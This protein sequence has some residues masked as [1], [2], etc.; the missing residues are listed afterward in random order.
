VTRE[1][2]EK[3]NKSANNWSSTDI[4]ERYDRFGRILYIPSSSSFK[5][6]RPAFHIA[7]ILRLLGSRVVWS[8]ATSKMPVKTALR[9][10]L[11]AGKGPKD[12]DTEETRQWLM[13]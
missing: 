8:P 6:S 2:A 5:L 9:T 7:Y 13:M 1:I 3:N 11:G 4:K 10:S 12:V